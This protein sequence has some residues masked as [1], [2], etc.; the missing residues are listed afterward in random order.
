MLANVILYRNYAEVYI[1]VYIF[2]IVKDN[3]SQ[4]VIEKIFK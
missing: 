4:F 3:I 1:L 2:L